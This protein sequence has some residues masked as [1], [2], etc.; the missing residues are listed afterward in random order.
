MFQYTV[1][2]DTSEP[3][4]I[5]PE[6]VSLEC[7]FRHFNR[8]P[9][10]FGQENGSQSISLGFRL[11]RS[12]AKT[13]VHEGRLT[14]ET[15]FASPEQWLPF[16]MKIPSNVLRSDEDFEI[17]VDLILEGGFWFHER[18]HHGSRFRLN[19][20]EPASGPI[21]I[22]APTQING[23]RITET[24]LPRLGA[25]FADMLGEFDFSD[26]A[27]MSRLSRDEASA[28]PRPSLS[29]SLLDQ[30]NASRLVSHDKRVVLTRL[31]D[32]FMRVR[33]VDVESLIG[34]RAGR[35]DLIRRFFDI[36]PQ[37]AGEASDYIPQ[38]LAD[39]LNEFA[40][41]DG[42]F[43]IPLSRLMMWYWLSEERRL[44]P[45]MGGDR[46]MIY[47]WWVTGAMPANNVPDVFIP[48]PVIAHLGG[49][50]EGFRGRILELSR[51]AYRA[52]TESEQLKLRYDLKK[53]S[54]LVAYSFDFLIHSARNH[55]NRHLIGSGVRAYWQEAFNFGGK[56]F[57]RF[58]VALLAQMTRF[59]STILIPTNDKEI[60]VARIFIDEKIP[61]LAPEWLPFC[62]VKDG[63]AFKNR[64][65]AVPRQTGRSARDAISEP[66]V[67]AGLVGS[68]SGLG[69]NLKMSCRTF[70]TMGKPMCVYDT[71]RRRVAE[72]ELAD[73]ATATLFHV[74]ADMLGEVLATDT[75]AMLGD[76][77][78]I[79]FFLW[80]LDVLPKAHLFGTELIDEI[81]A[82]SEFVANIYA[83]ATDKPVKI[84]KKYIVMPEMA[85]EKPVEKDRR[86]R[87]LTSFDFHSGVERK[88]PFAVIKAF[89][90]AFPPHVDDVRLT[91]KTTEFVPGH[92]GDANNQWFL[93]NEAATADRRIDIIV[94][95]MP[96][97][98]FFEMIRTHDCI[99]SSHRAEGFGY[100]PAYG[101]NFGK[102][103]IVTDYSGTTDFCSTE[104]SYPVS[105]R[106]IPVRPHEFIVNVPGARW[107]EIDHDHLVETM[108][109]VFENRA[110]A[111]KRG[112]R[113][114]AYIN[115][116]Y[117][118]KAQAN[119]Y[120][121]A[122]GEK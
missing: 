70:E 37:F 1:E 62:R 112:E 117:S 17:L 108:R 69:V 107:A 91:V 59:R 34:T 84:V 102:P 94:D 39:E 101:M 3:I 10:A 68:P 100:L 20:I 7:M 109:E 45:A 44:T 89:Q 95:A 14:P 103:V 119:R 63:A 113:A 71:V 33:Q 64:R 47:W 114:R 97:R 36:A 82:P 32:Y 8:A 49:A 2:M 79:G 51:F 43:E 25:G 86:Y 9:I 41:F 11:F 56:D 29:P 16:E 66:I 65:P 120:K 92:W 61:L 30:F 116:E 99:V 26:Y 54:G 23:H 40:L 85:A 106:L 27:A 38:E 5:T 60:S 4:E 48:K 50:H 77:K 73:R 104:T 12:R 24:G 74:N 13:L 88:N 115:S 67:I 55:I 58:E 22:A 98:E 78:R 93:I 6:G 53:T 80:E 83:S 87:F 75:L 90:D 118:L 105:C 19:F 122:L 121:E 76:R 15:N 28:S 31:M 35:F 81:W 18:G 52:Y 72:P 96:E 46:E 21:E 57:T 42:L 111:R 110:A